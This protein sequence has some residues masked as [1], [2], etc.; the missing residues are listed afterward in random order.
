MTMG[1]LRQRMLDGSREERGAALILT[2]IVLLVLVSVVGLAL[3]GG[4]AYNT[5]RGTQNAADNAA[6]AAA[7]AYCS[8]LSDPIGHGIQTA[9]ANGYD[10]SDVT[11]TQITPSSSDGEF[12]AVI[13]TTAETSFGRIM[14]V[15]E[16]TVVSEATAA[17]NRSQSSGPAAMFA[18]GP[19]PGCLLLK[20]GKANVTGF[21]YSAGDM[22]WNGGGSHML[23]ADVH[24]D[25]NLTINGTY[26]ILGTATASGTSNEAQ[27][28]TGVPKLNLDYPIS[29]KISDFIPGSPIAVA[30]GDQYHFH[31]GNVKAS[32]IQKLGPGI[33]F[34]QGNVTNQGSG[35]K[36]RPYTIVATGTIN[37]N[38]PEFEAFYQGLAMMAGAFSP[39]SCDSAAIDLGGNNSLLDGILFAPNGLLR[40]QGGAVNGGM[41]AWAID[42]GGN[43]DLTVNPDL[44]P[45]GDPAVFLLD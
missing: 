45:T 33:H 39:P 36:G 1:W 32:D 22:E 43:L 2:A 3:D 9:V 17:C 28:I 8:N 34:V 16:M 25:G 41:I 21:V 11:I 40:V 19:N 7:W 15:Q 20:G 31:A 44:F 42:T 18:K 26:N 38:S 23:D 35:L 4:Q 29:F 37:M 5:R 6:L 10:A 13:T 27:V 24:S 14:G 12:N 30:T